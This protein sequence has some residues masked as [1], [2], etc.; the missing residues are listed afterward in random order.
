MN[1]M[2]DSIRLWIALVPPQMEELRTHHRIQPD[3]H[4]SRIDL[5]ATHAPIGRAT[6]VQWCCGYLVGERFDLVSS[7]GVDFFFQK[8]MMSRE[9]CSIR[10]SIPWLLMSRFVSVLLGTE[11]WA[12]CRLLCFKFLFEPCKPWQNGGKLALGACDR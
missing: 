5:S 3:I 9:D 11:E 12:S 1:S 4:T 10:S 6:D 2:E 7:V 8:N